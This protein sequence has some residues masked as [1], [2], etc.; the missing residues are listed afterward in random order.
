MS[1]GRWLF[2]AVAVA[3]AASPQAQVTVRFEPSVVALAAGET[4]LVEVH[5][6]GLDA[7]GLTAFEANLRFDDAVAAIDDPNAGFV[8]LVTPF[9]PL[10]S[11]ALCTTV[12][13]TPECTDPDWQ[14]IATGRSAFFARDDASFAGRRQVVYGSTGGQAPASLDG[15]IMLVALR[16]VADGASVVTFDGA[17]VGA[18][19][20]PRRL[21]YLAQPLYLNAGGQPDSDADGIPDSIDNCI[22]NPN[23]DQR[24]SNADGFGNRCDPDLNNDG[25]VNVIDLGL[26]RSVFFT[27]DA[28]ADFS[29]DGIVNVIDLGILR[30]FFFRPP[31]PSG[32]VP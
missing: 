32:L 23:L 2:V 22:D 31:G 10:G 13:G 4:Q 25:I 7:A 15:A 11:Q 17:L 28:D 26:F 29:G 18:G 1:L 27:P 9:A 12:R 21:D 3:F 16:A 24:D 6:S 30:T 19:N 8:G 14:L 20:P 5:V